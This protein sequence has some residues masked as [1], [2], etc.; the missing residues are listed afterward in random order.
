MKLYLPCVALT[1]NAT[2]GRCQEDCTYARIR[3][4]SGWLKRA[5]NHTQTPQRMKRPRDPWGFIFFGLPSLG[6]GGR[7]T[8]CRYEYVFLHIGV[9]RLFIHHLRCD[10]APTI[11]RVHTVALFERRPSHGSPRCG[12]CSGWPA[13][14]SA[15]VGDHGHLDF[16]FAAGKQVALHFLDARLVFLPLALEQLRQAQ[17]DRKPAD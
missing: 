7:A 3:P 14:L 4:A 6:G 17:A 13:S 12:T 9:M 8:R 11:W 10:L 16:Q 5:Q 1:G 15:A 2:G